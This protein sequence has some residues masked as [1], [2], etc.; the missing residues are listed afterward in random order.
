MATPLEKEFFTIA[1]IDSITSV[2]ATGRT[3]ITIQFALDR[4]IDAAAL[5]VQAA[6]GLARRRLPTNMTNDPSF[7]KVNPADL[8]ILYLRV[9]SPTLPL[10]QLN[11]YADTLI[12]QRLSMVKGVAQVVIYGQKKY[13]VRVQLDPDALATRGLG[14]DEVSEAIMA[15]NS[16]LPTGSL[17][18][19]RRSQSIKASG[20][21]EDARAFRDVIVP[22][23]TA[24][25]CAC[26]TSAGSSTAWS[27]T[28][29]SPGAMTARPASPLAVERQPGA[30]TVEVVDAIRALLPELSGRCRPPWAWTSSMTAPRPSANPWPK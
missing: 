7:R 16:K 18:G 14:I 29:S 28:S 21:L 11:E 4:D 20:Q 1:G 17:D 22:T 27:R 9:S 24:R 5:D 6:I 3:R 12:G 15:A 10:Y 25:P 2:N 30:N 26:A 8:P 23:A 13:A 19:A